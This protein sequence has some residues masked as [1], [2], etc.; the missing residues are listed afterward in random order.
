MSQRKADDSDSRA[1]SSDLLG[2]EQG[3]EPT[4]EE[5]ATEEER[6]PAV[7]E[8]GIN[9][10]TDIEHSLG[11]EELDVNLF[12]SKSLWVPAR[13]RGVFGGQV[14]GQSITAANKT[15]RDNVRLH[16]LHCY[17]LMAGDKTVPIIYDVKRLRDG[18]SYQTRSVEARQRGRV[19]FT[20][21]LVSDC[22]PRY[23]RIHPAHHA[24]L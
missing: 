19:I 14:I 18:G 8:N 10:P 24:L 13:A 17:F 22:K 2:N 23:T 21:M 7:Y 9:Q 4:S 5:P 3:R 15:V 20:I 6:E 11:V 12:R 1:R 16:S